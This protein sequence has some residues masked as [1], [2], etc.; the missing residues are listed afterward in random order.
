MAPYNN[1]LKIN[2]FL[3][4]LI[5]MP[6]EKNDEDFGLPKAT[7]FKLIQDLTPED[8]AIT[9]DVRNAMRE[10]AHQFLNT[11][12]LDANTQCE[13]IEKKKTISNSH[14][15]FALEKRGFKNFV[16][17]CQKVSGDYEDYSKHKPSKQ[18]KLKSSGKSMEEL[19]EDQRMLFKQAAKLQ[20]ELYEMDDESESKE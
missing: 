17:E 2:K 18:N 11:I 19:E 8:Y 3:N 9:K 7:V 15:Y 10:A 13:A 16:V 4:F 20:S 6:L 14:I 12:A 1:Y 5:G